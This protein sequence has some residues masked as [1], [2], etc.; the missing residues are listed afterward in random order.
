MHATEIYT[1]LKNKIHVCMISTVELTLRDKPVL[2]IR[3]SGDKM[4]WFEI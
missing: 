4:T 1:S 3:F 2:E